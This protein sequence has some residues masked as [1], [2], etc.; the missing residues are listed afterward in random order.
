MLAG[1]VSLH[2]KQ[3]AKAGLNIIFFFNS[4][5]FLA[6]NLKNQKDKNSLSSCAIYFSSLALQASAR[7]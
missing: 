7:W 3:L 1:H 2:F 6:Y 5:F 4:V